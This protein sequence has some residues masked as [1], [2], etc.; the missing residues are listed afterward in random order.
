MRS[1]EEIS[2]RIMERGD[3]LIESAKVR[4]AKIKHTS[5]AVSG[6]C[7]AAIAGIG[8]WHIASNVKK[9]DDGFKGSGIVSAT[10]TVTENTSSAEITTA[11]TTTSPKATAAAKTT[12]VTTDNKNSDTT[13]AVPA[14]TTAAVQTTSV[15]TSTVPVTTSGNNANET[16]IPEYPAKTTTADDP[17]PVT[18]TLR[19]V[20][21]DGNG[22]GN[23]GEESVRITTSVH[24]EDGPTTTSASIN[25]TSTETITTAKSGPQMGDGGYVP[26]T[27]TTTTSLQDV[28]RAN[29]SYITLNEVRYEKQAEVSVESIGS[30]LHRVDVHIMY[31]RQNI[32]SV[33]KAYLIEGVD[34]EEA[35]A[36]QLK[37]TDEYYL[38][39]NTSYKKDEAE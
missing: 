7:A 10:E 31:I 1:Y 15:K 30:Y 25:E 11:L 20:S 2:N 27:S 12:K 38:F 18:T 28:F 21:S 9:P 37:D 26:S 36:V 14:V 13:S 19:P 24:I 5:Y 23:S 35:V 3:K 4:A 33:M 6:M 32:R 22:N 16:A 17:T 8:V 39:R 29:P 34:E